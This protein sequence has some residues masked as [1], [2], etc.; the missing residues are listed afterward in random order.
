MRFLVWLALYCSAFVLEAVVLPVFFGLRLPG[1]SF[2][3][4]VTG[5][6]FQD[7]WAGFWFAVCTGFLRDVLASAAFPYTIFFLCIFGVLQLFY[8]LVQWEDP[9]RRLGALFAGFLLAPLAWVAS[10]AFGHVLFRLPLRAITP[11]DLVSRFALGEAAFAALWLLVVS[12]CVLRWE[13][14]RRT[15]AAERI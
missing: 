9:P 6:A 3:V 15:F 7:F 13:R 14:R 5:I 8:T 2:A 12:W 10:A 1:V 11:S 4:L